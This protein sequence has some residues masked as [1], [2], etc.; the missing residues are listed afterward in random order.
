MVMG[1]VVGTNL[2]DVILKRRYESE[3]DSVWSVVSFF[4]GIMSNRQSSE[5][6][7]TKDIQR[8]SV[9]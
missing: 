8:S 5:K 3:S 1:S 4:V 6:R 2:D 9:S 7:L